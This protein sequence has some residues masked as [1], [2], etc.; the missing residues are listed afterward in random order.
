MSAQMIQT[1]VYVAGIILS[2]VV[3]LA[4]AFVYISDRSNNKKSK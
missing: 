3:I 2:V 1:S 4:V